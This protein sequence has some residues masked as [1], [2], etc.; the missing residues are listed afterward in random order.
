MLGAVIVPP[1]MSVGKPSTPTRSTPR[2]LTD[3]GAHRMMSLLAGSTVIVYGIA[4]RR[5]G[6][7]VRRL[8]QG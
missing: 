6:A 5:L 8:S 2:A 1:S 7:R 3:D 4:V